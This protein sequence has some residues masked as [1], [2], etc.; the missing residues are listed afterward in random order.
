LAF[1][2][3]GVIDW[4]ALAGRYVLARVRGRDPWA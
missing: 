2:L 3:A 4:L 1:L